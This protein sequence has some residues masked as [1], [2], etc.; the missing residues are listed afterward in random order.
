MWKT[1][2]VPHSNMQYMPTTKGIACASDATTSK[3]FTFACSSANATGFTLAATGKGAMA[4]FTYTVTQSGAK[5]TTVPTDSGWTGSS[6]C[7]VTKKDGT[8]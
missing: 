7:W 5:T 3:H 8:C 1:A 2:S 6:T 4:G